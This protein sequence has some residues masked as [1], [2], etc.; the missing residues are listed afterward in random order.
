MATWI[1]EAVK[2][3]TKPAAVV[4]I[5]FDSGTRKYSIDYIR[6]IG[7]PAYKG[8]IL[9][10]PYL[11]DSIGDL[12]RT[13]IYSK[14]EIILADADREFRT[15]VETEGIKNR[16][17]RI[18]LLFINAVVP[19]TPLTR[20]T[21][22][23]YNWNPMSGM[24]FKIV[25]EQKSKN[26]ENKYPEDIVEKSDYANVDEFG[27]GLLIP[28]PYG[29]ISALGLS[30]DGAFPCILVDPTV[31]AERHLVGLQ[32]YE[33][34]VATGE[35]DPSIGGWGAGNLAVLAS[36]ANGRVGK[37]LSITEGGQDWPNAY[38]SITVTPGSRYRV[39]C[40]IKAGTE[41]EYSVW[42]WDITNGAWIV[43]GTWKTEAAGDWS[44]NEETVFTAP[45]GCIEVRICLYSRSLNGEGFTIY[46]D[47]VTATEVIYVPR[48]Y[49]NGTLKTINTHYT[50]GYGIIGTESGFVLNGGFP[51]D[52]A[53][54]TARRSALL[55]SVAGG[56]TGNC[57]RIT[58]NGG[59]F[60][61]ASQDVVVI[62]GSR[63]HLSGYVKAG[64]QDWWTIFITNPATGETIY[65]TVGSIVPADWS[66]SFNLYFNIPSGCTTA[67]IELSCWSS[68]GDGK[69]IY[70]DTISCTVVASTVHVTID[71]KAGVNPTTDD[72]VSCDTLFGSRYVCEAWKHFLM[73]FCGHAEAD[74]HAAS[75]NVAHEIE[76]NRDYTLDGPFIKEE[77]LISHENQIRNEFEL[78]IWREPKDG[79][80][81][82]KYMSSLDQPVNHYRDYLDILKGYEPNRK[83]TKIINY[84]KYMYNYNFAR[85]YFY[86]LP[87]RED[88][89]SQSKHG[90]TYRSKQGFYFVRKSSVASDLAAR[91]LLRRKDPIVLDKF[92]L[93]LKAFYNSLADFIEITHFE[94]TGSEGYQKRPFQLRAVQD[95]LDSFTRVAVLE[96]ISEF[97]GSAFIMG[98]ADLPD[99]MT[100]T[101]AQR[102]K[103]GFLCD[104]V[105]EQYSNGDP[106]KR[107]RD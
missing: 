42:L 39:N 37:C 101:E 34:L 69:T 25:C 64:T 13:F 99:Y 31:D 66:T 56:K 15:L 71:W 11:S 36:A 97:I 46:Y 68:A 85:N 72:I 55:A 92:P 52:T 100:A 9:N 2:H 45:V 102:E 60:P 93:P 73:K 49:I 41:P 17:M 4:E 24:K 43:E 96:D 20:F 16:E 54:W 90:A 80:I 76:I 57:L 44:T 87:Y 61:T 38:Q 88:V 105:T 65:W 59:N 70:Y 14:I 50:I 48:A 27:L 19:I 86:N 63:Y 26:L 81:H 107:M 91:K 1:S 32:A 23:I 40:Y 75:Y 21:G 95:D 12:V 18:K 10:L 83:V 51:T 77:E 35:M 62:P 30:N 79:L 67:R 53:N 104:P 22:N 74:F 8:N 94:G 28:I 7:S 89:D 33:E 78:D 29:N 103:Y 47:S 84:L 5:D 82:F 6:P 58:E 3:T 106:A 98:P